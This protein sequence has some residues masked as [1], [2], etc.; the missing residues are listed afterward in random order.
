R[1]IIDKNVHIPSGTNIGYN[2][3]KDR[4]RYPVTDSGI[5]VIPRQEPG[6]AVP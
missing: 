1:V 6:H 3:D 5:V 2:S 4:E